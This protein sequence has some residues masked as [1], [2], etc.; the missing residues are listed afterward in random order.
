MRQEI[1]R[2]EASDAPAVFV[3]V[4]A[5]RGYLEALKPS[6]QHELGYDDD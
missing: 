2:R 5:L 3:C 1:K 6:A 4:E